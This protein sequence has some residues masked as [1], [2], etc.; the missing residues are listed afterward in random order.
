MITGDKRMLEPGTEAYERY[1]LQ[2]AQVDELRVFVWGPRNILTAFGILTAALSKHYDVIT[3]QD[4]L[5]RGFLGLVVA[6]LAA[7]KLQVQVHGDLRAVRGLNHVLLQIVLWHADS[8]RVVSEKVKAQVEQVGVRVFVDVLPVYIDLE[9]IRAAPAADL[10]KE[11]PH[12]G[13]FLL[14]VG[15]L[16]DEKNPKEAID[17]F[18]HVAEEFPG[19]GLIV[20][21]VGSRQ[22]ALEAHARNLGLAGR[23][24]C[25]GY[26]TDLPSLYKAADGMLVTSSYESFGAAIVEALS[27]GCPVVTTDVGVAK[28]AG[29]TVVERDALAPALLEILKTGARGQLRMPLPTRD[30]WAQQWRSIL[31]H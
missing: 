14:F 10:K 18:A 1:M 16:E 24:V 22:A 2:R 25:V 6:R 28:E 17:V 15:R 9:A 13:K 31:T 27:A 4:A 23:V 29:A 7:S 12:F 20:V 26:R 8:V 5:W 11:F 3:T 30:Q 21:G 19:A